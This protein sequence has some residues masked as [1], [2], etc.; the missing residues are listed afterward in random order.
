MAELE[1]AQ[2]EKEAQESALAA[3]MKVGKLLHMCLS[4]FVVNRDVFQVGDRCE[5]R[6]K[7]LDYSRR[8]AIVYIGLSS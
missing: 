5:V 4:N 7:D 3:N 2:S 6:T 8:G 1:A